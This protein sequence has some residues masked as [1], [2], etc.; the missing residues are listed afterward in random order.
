MSFI[1]RL[2]NVES[3]ASTITNSALAGVIKVYQ[4]YIKNYNLVWTPDASV[5]TLI[6]VEKT[7]DNCIEF[8]NELKVVN[9]NNTSL[10]EKAS[11][12][13]DIAKAYQNMAAQK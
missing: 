11:A 5:Q 12:Y 10:T 7:Q 2:A 4:G 13:S 3:K 6:E 1:N 9:E 8:I